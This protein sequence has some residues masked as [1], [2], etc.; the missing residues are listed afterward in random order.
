M[1]APV[2]KQIF[3]VVKPFLK[4]QLRIKF[5]VASWLMK[6]RSRCVTRITV[7]KGYV[8]ADR[9]IEVGGSNYIRN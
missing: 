3:G 6:L 9:E 1:R 8:M 4:R 7:I 5:Q 2:R